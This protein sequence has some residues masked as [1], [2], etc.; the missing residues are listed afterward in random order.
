MR[1]W[2]S[3]NFAPGTYCASVPQMKALTISAV[4]RAQRRSGR[5]L[6]FAKSGSMVELEEMRRKDKSNIY[7]KNIYYYSVTEAKMTVA[8]PSLTVLRCIKKLL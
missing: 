7:T 1:A 4:R 6:M 5:R 8:F 2:L 3:V